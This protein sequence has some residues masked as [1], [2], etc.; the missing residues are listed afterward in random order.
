M[1]QRFP[2]GS[3]HLLNLLD[4][5][6]LPYTRFNGSLFPA[7]DPSL[8]AKAPAAGSQGYA[9]AVIGFIRQQAPEVW[10]GVPTHFQ[11]TFLSSVGLADAFPNGNGNPALL[12]LRD[13]EVWGLPISQPADDPNNHQFVYQRFQRGVVHYDA[14]CHCTQGILLAD[15]LK[16]ILTAT[17]LPADLAREAADSRFL[18]QYCPAAPDWLCRPQDL[19]N[20]HLTNA[21]SP[22]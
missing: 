6:L 3:I 17:N 11:Q 18:A 12:P 15:Y 10:N 14:T 7:P 20:S 5:S 16:A 8:A 9:D 22:E 1:L 21:F 13:L 4:P 2:D 19:P